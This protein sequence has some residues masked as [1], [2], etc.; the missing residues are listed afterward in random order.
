[1]AKQSFSDRKKDH[2]RER[3]PSQENGKWRKRI[4]VTWKRTEKSFKKGTHKGKRREKAFE[5]H[6]FGKSWVGL[7]NVNCF[8]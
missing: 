8:A 4:R 3:N 7:L 1:L 5:T 6:G 2:G